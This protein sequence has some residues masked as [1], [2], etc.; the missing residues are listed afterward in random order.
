MKVNGASV[1]SIR[2]H[3]GLSLTKLA[4]AAGISKHTLWR[5]EHNVDQDVQPATV[6]A[7]AEALKCPTTAI[8]A[9]PSEVAS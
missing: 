7:I 1:V 4:A 3:A 9:L 2:E 6:K 5:I 8:V